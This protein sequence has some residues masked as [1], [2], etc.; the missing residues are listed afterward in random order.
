MCKAA[1]IRQLGRRRG[2]GEFDER[3]QDFDWHA[4]AAAG[5]AP[6]D[7]PS[8]V[9]RRTRTL[10]NPRRLRV[11]DFSGAPNGTDM[12]KRS[13]F[14]MRPW[15]ALTRRI[16][17]Q[18]AGIV[19]ADA[20]RGRF[21]EEGEAPEPAHRLGIAA[22]LAHM[23]KIRAEQEPARTERPQRRAVEWRQIFEGIGLPR[24]LARETGSCSR[25]SGWGRALRSR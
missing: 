10:S 12:V 4:A 24:I 14:A 18:L 15:F 3:A 23:R 17:P 9:S 21:V 1:E 13:T 20:P 6:A 7:T 22:G 8:A 19:F 16:L 5:L 2:P 25:C 11:A